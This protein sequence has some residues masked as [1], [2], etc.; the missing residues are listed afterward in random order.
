MCFVFSCL[1][2]AGTRILLRGKHQDMLCVLL[3]IERGYID[4]LT[5]EI[6]GCFVCVLLLIERGYMCFLKWE[7]PECE[8]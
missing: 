4:T 7:T 8:I 6:S 2:S 5:W 1:L 3:I